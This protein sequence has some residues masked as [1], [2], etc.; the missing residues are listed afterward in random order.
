MDLNEEVNWNNFWDKSFEGD[1][2]VFIIHLCTNVI[3]TINA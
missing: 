2:D 1:Q 3:T